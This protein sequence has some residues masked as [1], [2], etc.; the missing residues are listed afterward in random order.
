MKFLFLVQGEGRG[1][2]TQAIALSAMLQ[3]A[4]HEVVKVLIGKSPRR[5][6][7]QFFY[8]KIN[9]P[10]TVFESPNFLVDAKNK[11]IRIWS[12]IWYNLFKSGMFFKS[13]AA[14]HEAVQET[15]PD[16]IINFYELLGGL[17]AGL[18][19]PKAR[20]MV[21]GHQYLL[22]H[23]EFVF[24]KGYWID[25]RLLSINSWV[26]ALRAEKKLALS[27][28]PMADVPKKRIYVVPPLLRAEVTKLKSENRGFI[29]GY[30]LN[31]GYAEDIER[32]HKLHPEY[33]LH[34]FWDKSDAPED[35]KMDENLWFHRLNDTRFLDYMSKCGGYCSTAGFESICEAMYLGKPIMMVPTYGH[36]EQ[37]CNA[38]DAVLSGAGIQNSEF[39]LNPF[40]AYLPKHKDI[41]S[42]FQQ[43]VNSAKTRF[44]NLLTQ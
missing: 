24:P 35:L 38:L 8:E 14:I 9:A 33:E 39:N 42:P 43:W 13:I 12:S 20:I 28:R 19:K 16:V 6:I 27:F 26:I 40:I 5:Q 36:F 4:G 1:H 37:A 23:P 25:K 11:K 2:M 22:Q 30:I 21:V 44:I 41:S 10:V 3:S 29:L 32:W 7:P 18:Y 17:Y 15:K 34:F 31:A